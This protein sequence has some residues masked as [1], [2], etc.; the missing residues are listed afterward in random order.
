MESGIPRLLYVVNNAAFF[1]SHR[2]PIA[3]AA[4][5]AGWDVHVAM[6]EGPAAAEVRA[7]GF[8]FHRIALRRGGLSAANGI[9]VVI[10]QAATATPPSSGVARAWTDRP[11]G[12]AKAP[13][14]RAM[15]PTS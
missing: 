15:R 7:E 6:P 8:A 11:P 13:Q 3:R 2:L 14:R 9:R 5:A 1:L 12:H 10:A 4:R